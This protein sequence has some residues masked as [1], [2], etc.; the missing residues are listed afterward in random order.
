VSLQ[1]GIPLFIVAALLQAT[2]LPH[3]RVFGGQ[4]DLVVI[5]V[6]AWA[7]LDSDQEGMAWAFV[8]GFFLDLLSGV[9]LGVSSLA[10]V[11]I[12]YFVGLA[13]AQLYR[14]NLLLLT[15]LALASTLAYHLG[16][17]FLL[18]FLVDYPVAWPGAFWY[19]TL[20]SVALDTI[21]IIPAL[22]LLQRPYNRLHPR[23]VTF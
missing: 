16:Y 20:P 22:R 11:P 6:L 2:I 23:R 13:E 19:V 17:V 5:L 1:V 7:T 18:R 8:G 21:L 9:P 14:N 4:P 3:L 15:G 12:A 10:L